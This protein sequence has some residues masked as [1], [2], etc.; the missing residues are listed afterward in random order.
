MSMLY[1]LDI[2]VK[3]VAYFQ[4]LIAPANLFYEIHD[5]RGRRSST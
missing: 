3:Q 4:G 5:Q 2:A 1:R